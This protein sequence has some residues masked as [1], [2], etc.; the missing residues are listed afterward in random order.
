MNGAVERVSVNEYRFATRWSVDAAPEEVFTVLTDPDR[1]TSWWPAVLRSVEKIEVGDARD[2]EG[3]RVRLSTQGWLPYRLRW[4]LTVVRYD[5]PVLLDFEASG[6]LVGRGRWLVTG[7]NGC[8]TVHHMWK[9]R[10]DKPLLR[11]GSLLLKPVF[12]MNHRW[13]MARGRESLVLELARRRGEPTEPPPGPVSMARSAAVLVGV[14]VAVT[15]VAIT[16]ARGAGS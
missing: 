4:D 8:A 6:D 11:V 12:A 16:V 5:P 9:V 1:L 10:A 3:R 15:M 2:A 7:R 13:A 14:A